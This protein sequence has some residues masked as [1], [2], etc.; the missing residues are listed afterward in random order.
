M[1]ARK[2]IDKYRK[3]IREALLDLRVWFD[4]EVQNIDVHVSVILIQDLL[5]VHINRTIHTR[6]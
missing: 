6:K 1:K 3:I 4:T 5:T 2:Y